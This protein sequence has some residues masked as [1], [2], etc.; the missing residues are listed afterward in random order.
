MRDKH[1]S[2][3]RGS[4]TIPNT[5]PQSRTM[6]TAAERDSY[7]YCWLSKSISAYLSLTKQRLAR[8]PSDNARR[9]VGTGN[10][11]QRSRDT[12][13]GSFYLRGCRHS[14]RV[15][16]S[17]DV[18][19]RDVSTGT[20]SQPAA[21][22]ASPVGNRETSSQLVCCLVTTRLSSH[23]HVVPSN[24]SSFFGEPRFHVT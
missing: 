11:S 23:R 1:G 8:V 17:R 15:R 19:H 13:R 24:V 6:Q 20:F 9:H 5:T 10:L 7:A 12:A 14:Y 4:A 16:H 21:A 18:R 3:S 22:H 2:I